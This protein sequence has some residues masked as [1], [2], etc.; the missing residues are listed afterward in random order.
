MSHL[1]SEYI[2]Q[3]QKL[4][5]FLERH[6][7]KLEQADA[8][9]AEFSS[10]LAETKYN[11]AMGLVFAKLLQ[12]LDENKNFSAFH[13]NNISALYESLIDLQM[14][15]LDNYVE[16]GHFEYAV[17]DNLAKAQNIVSKGLQVASYKTEELKLLLEK[18]EQ[19]IQLQSTK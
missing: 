12:C 2:D 6:K 7:N 8:N 13:L 9:F 17:M 18:I 10:M 15:N 1:I 16:A 4:H 19:D 11:A 3:N 14:N 5:T